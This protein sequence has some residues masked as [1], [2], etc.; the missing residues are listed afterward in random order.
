MAAVTSPSLSLGPRHTAHSAPR[1]WPRPSSIRPLP[2][3]DV[4]AC[5]FGAPGSLVSSL[6]PH[7]SSY[8]QGCRTAWC[9]GACHRVPVNGGAGHSVKLPHADRPPAVPRA[10][11]AGLPLRGH[12]CPPP[13]SQ[14]DSFPPLTSGSNVISVTFRIRKSPYLLGFLHGTHGLPTPLEREGFVWF[15]YCCTPRPS[16]T[17]GI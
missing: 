9:G 1:A 11:T 2:L 3:A 5:P 12:L 14:G 6:A 16:T 4:V 17:S 8:H 10:S 7:C 15:L 13:A